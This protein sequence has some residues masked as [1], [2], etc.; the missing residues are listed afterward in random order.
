MHLLWF[1]DVNCKMHFF[2]HKS[3]D[4]FKNCFPKLFSIY[5]Q[6]KCD[7]IN[8]SYGESTILPDYGRF[9]DLANEVGSCT[10]MLFHTHLF[11][12]LLSSLRVLVKI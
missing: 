11:L 1:I 5:I 8:M 7:L 10:A 9:I 3:K 2:S 4:T 6:H 12:D